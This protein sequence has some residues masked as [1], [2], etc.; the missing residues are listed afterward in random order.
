MQLK[1]QIRSLGRRSDD[2]AIASVM[3]LYQKVFEV[4]DE[5]LQQLQNLI[6]D[7]S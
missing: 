4:I 6:D 3:S 2:E 5:T 7:E 1:T